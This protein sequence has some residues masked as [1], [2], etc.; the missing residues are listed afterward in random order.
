MMNALLS[1][2][3]QRW[4]LPVAAAGTT[5]WL[6]FI[7]LGGTPLIRASGLALVIVGVA[8]TLRRWGG[9]LTLAGGLALAFSPAFWSQTGGAD[10]F[11]LPLMLA[12]LAVAALVAGVALWVGKRPALSLAV[13]VALFAALFLTV[14]SEPGSL[15]LT[16]LTA[17][18]LLFLLIDALLLTNPRF[19]EAL[20]A[21][22]RRR[23]ILGVLLLLLIGVLND[24]LLTLLAPALVLGLLASR[25]PLP[26]WYWAGLAVI[27]LFGSYRLYVAYIDSGWWLFPAAEAEA[28]GYRMPYM[29]ADAWRESSRW[30]NLI[31]LI[32]EQFTVMGLLVGV[33][34]LAR[35][36]RWYPPLGVVTLVAY[37][38][39]FTFGLVYFGRDNAVLL[40][41]LLMIQVIWLSYGVYSIGQWL[42][43][44][45]STRVVAWIA[46]AVFGLLPLLLLLRATGVI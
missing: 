25:T 27:A 4:L 14:I 2:E 13:G 22:L 21:A 31:G 34:G 39:Y 44:L 15:R 19:D 46:P 42:Q 40:L 17:A 45:A 29:I 38:T 24:P 23:H 20:P 10:R 7:L 1:S 33:F 18:W 28:L 16:T 35:L 41:P 36:A 37:G 9:L 8:L 5:A 43:R 11:S 30:V 6:A 32:V 3:Q 12:A 26:R